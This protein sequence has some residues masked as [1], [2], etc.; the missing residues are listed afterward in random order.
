VQIK[1]VLA[2]PLAK[3]WRAHRSDSLAVNISQ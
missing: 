3:R 1:Q 2:K